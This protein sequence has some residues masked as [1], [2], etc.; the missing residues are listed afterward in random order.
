MR[1]IGWN[2]RELKEMGYV[3]ATNGDL[4]DNRDDFHAD[5]P[6]DFLRI[7]DCRTLTTYN[8]ET[9]IVMSRA[10]WEKI[11]AIAEESCSS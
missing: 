8:P 4:L 9:H 3:V 2:H 11:A 6:D 1:H 7:Y 10:L 5:H